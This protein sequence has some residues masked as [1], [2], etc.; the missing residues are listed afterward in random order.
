MFSFVTLG[1]FLLFIGVASAVTYAGYRMFRSAQIGDEETERRLAKEE[2]DRAAKVAAKY[3][4]KDVDTN[5]DT[6][7]KLR[8]RSL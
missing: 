6:L 8:D 1:L 7:D 3:P 2:A 4:G 5:K